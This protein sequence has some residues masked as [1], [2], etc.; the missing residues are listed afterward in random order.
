M[1]SSWWIHAV[2]WPSS[3]TC[4]WKWCP[5]L[6]ALS[7]SQALSSGWLACNSLVPP[8]CS[9]GRH[10]WHCHTV[11]QHKWESSISWSTY[12]NSECPSSNSIPGLKNHHVDSR[13]WQQFGSWQTYQ[14]KRKC[15]KAMS[16]TE[17]KLQGQ[18][19][20]Y[21]FQKFLREVR[22]FSCLTTEIMWLLLSCMV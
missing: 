9:S 1:A 16:K 5:G 14:K 3:P 17:P 2:G 22:N 15:F 11:D 4:A 8:S 10:E 13:L 12:P 18:R 19:F 6:V 20:Q 7:L 21:C